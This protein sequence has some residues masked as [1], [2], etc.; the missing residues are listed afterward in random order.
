[1]SVAE[2]VA[3][4]A[5]RGIELWLEGGRLRFRA[6]QGAMTPDLRDRLAQDKERVIAH[7]EAAASGSRT[8]LPLSYN[9]QAL[10]FLHRAAPRS[11]AYNVGVAL[12]VRSA[13][14]VDA[15]RQALQALVDRHAT[16]RT[17]YQEGAELVQL[18]YGRR[19]VAFEVEHLPGIDEAALRARVAELHVE[20]F[21]LRN[22]PLF[23][24]RLLTV[25]PTH[26]V[27]VITVHHSAADGRSTWLLLDELRAQYRANVEQTPTALTKPASEYADY[28]RWQRELLESPRGRQLH[29]YWMTRLSGEL[30]VLDLP[31]DLPR[32]AVQRYA[33]ATH[34]FTISP[35][36]TQRLRDFAREEGATLFVVLL[37]AFQAFLSRFTRQTDVIVGTP[38]LGRNQ[39]E[40]Q[41]V[42]GDFVNMVSLRADL[43]GD[44]SFRALVGHARTTVLEAV[45]HEDYP[46]ALLVQ[47]LGI[48][49]DPSRSPVVQAMFLLQKPQRS[50]DLARLF[51]VEAEGPAS[52]DFGGM[53]VEGFPLRQQE[54]QFDLTLELAEAESNLVANLKYNVDLFEPATIARF[55]S[56][57]VT[58]LTSAMNDANVPVSR[59][60]IMPQSDRT[61]IERWNA[62]VM[63]YDPAESVERLFAAQAARTPQAI[64]VESESGSLTYAQLDERSTQLA[65]FLRG[66]GVRPETLVGICLQRTPDLVVAV[67]GVLKSGGAYV[68]LDPSFP[69]HRIAMM[70]EDARLALILTDA[71]SE[72]V[73]P[74]SSAKRI[75]LDREWSRI[76][77]QPADAAPS[78]A[79]ED[80]TAYVL[81]TS[82]S[83][84]KPKGVQIP[85]RA[86]TNFIRSMQE[87]PGIAPRDKL[88][89]VTTLSFDI[90]GLELYLPLICG[91]TIVLATRDQASDGVELR[92]LLDSSG[93]TMMQATPATWRMLIDAGWE[94]TPGLR[95]LCGGEALSRELAA[96]LVARGASVW[97]M[98][99]PT[100]TTIWSTVDRV[101]GDDRI[102]IGKPIGNT[103]VHVVDRHGEPVPVGM[104]GELCIGGDG[105]ALGYLGR[106]D[107]TAERF[108]ADPFAAARPDARM[109]KT[110]DIARWLPD[111]RLECFGRVDHQVKVRGFRIELSEVESVL[112]R[113][114]AIR[115]AVASVHDEG[116]GDRRLVAYV[117]H[118]P[119]ADVTT[120][121]LRRFMRAELPEYMVPSLFIVM[122]AMP[123]TPNGKVDRR[124]LPA[125]FAQGHRQGERVPPRTEME[126]MVAGVWADLL[127]REDIS[128]HD[129]FFDIGGHSL[130]AMQAISAIER[131]TGLR[132]NPARF[133]LDTLDQISATCEQMIGP[134]AENSRT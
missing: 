41:A 77:F 130:L 75:Y 7:L 27:L 23:R 124:A 53:T 108:V 61:N 133:M 104:P 106:P 56:A 12:R 19:D 102:T 125:P 21:D 67:L 81:Y 78:A 100:E 33:G 88:L 52:I 1:M 37:A 115:Q 46:F 28:V 79:R 26:H 113:H 95:I 134:T 127:K 109:Y 49:P 45:A 47:Q 70:A 3:D 122:D 20:P 80:D 129:N 110:G 98:Y 8:S 69:E 126:L 25:S 22:G 38:A 101:A 6:P 31:A 118:A 132:L 43:S 4:L 29:D 96:Q 16:L 5:A 50:A 40:F 60:S 94:G 64:A 82:G 11:P 87:T 91:A 9:Q 32:P 66:E 131:K 62:T 103:T 89:A 14:N 119:G 105:V 2:L 112:E 51:D 18:V 30:P 128:V 111:G 44:P 10:W 114:E 116:G 84:G 93:A 63:P 34:S 97:N 17:V 68:P 76:D 71:D 13:V 24:A 123:L 86:L 39:A 120:S 121:D 74:E 92:D 73:L 85:R 58:L 15:L 35:E 55:E 59:L 83:T 99:G 54:G 72:D 42:V 90:S 107:L 48:R 65:V 57:F 36:L 117:Q